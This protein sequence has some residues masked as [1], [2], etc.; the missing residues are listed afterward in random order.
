MGRL[1][2]ASRFPPMRPQVS[3][4]RGSDRCRTPAAAC[5]TRPGAPRPP[6]PSSIQP[7]SPNLRPSTDPTQNPGATSHSPFRN[8]DIRTIVATGVRQD[9]GCR[10][11]CWGIS[12]WSAPLCPLDL[13]RI[14]FDLPYAALILPDGRLAPARSACSASI[15]WQFRA[16]HRG[17]ISLHLRNIALHD[18]CLIPTQC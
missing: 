15:G 9:Y 18:C 17:N 8:R 5:G 2:E 4:G 14:D 10:A 1:T 16:K 13:A 7:C 12:G 3:G 6:G 11:G